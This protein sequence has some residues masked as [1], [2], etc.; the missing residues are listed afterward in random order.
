MAFFASAKATPNDS[1]TVFIFLSETCPICQTATLELKNIYNQ[2]HPK[3][4]EFIGL[5]PNTEMSNVTSITKFGQKYNLPFLL[6]LDES[7]QKVKQFSAMVT[8][9]VFVVRN[10]DNQIMYNGRI[11][12][13]FERVGKKRQV[14]TEFYLKNALNEILAHQPVTV[15]ETSPVGCF[16]N[17]K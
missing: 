2:Y 16:I 8:P 5:F 13:G 1:I 15:K 9:Q 4:I 11:D 3:G 12:N 7:Q 6:K 10:I 14:T 17:K